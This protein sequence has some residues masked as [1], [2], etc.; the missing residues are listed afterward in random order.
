MCLYPKLILNKRYLPSK[1]NKG[2]VPICKDER[3]RYVAVGCGICYECRKQKAN[4]WK[5]RLY[6]ELKTNNNAVFVTLTF[7]EEHLNKYN[8]IKDE[9]ELATKAVRH[10]LERVRKKTKKSLKHFLITEKGHEG[11]ERI[12]LHGIIW[13]DNVK[14]IC[15]EKWQN[16]YVYYGEYVN[17]Q[18]IN[19]IIKYILKPDNDHPD[20]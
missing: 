16:G 20:F 3:L 5:V 12:H 8:S 19:Y 18:T 9:N 17:N 7:D 15:E 11:T 6:E 13:G 14:E 2:I 10:F 1:K 4:Q